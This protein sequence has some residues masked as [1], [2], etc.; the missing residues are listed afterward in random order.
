MSILV[1]TQ[2]WKKIE[3]W[4]ASSQKILVFEGNSYRNMWREL[5]PGETLNFHFGIGVRPEGSNRGVCEW[6]TAEFGTIV[7]WQNVA[8]WTEVWPNLRLLNWTLCQFWGYELNIFKNLQFWGESRVLKT[9]KKKCWNGG[10]ASG[11]E[12]VKKGSSGPHIPVPHFSGSAPGEL[13]L[14]FWQICICF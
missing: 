12:G 3:I 14:T 4:E 8:L 11:K 13:T 9:E 6:T 5:T 1:H 7:N 10:L 2:G